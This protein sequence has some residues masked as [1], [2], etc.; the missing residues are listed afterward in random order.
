[1]FEG[2]VRAHCWHCCL[3]PPFVFGAAL[4]RLR[5]LPLEHRPAAPCS[6]AGARRPPPAARRPPPCSHP[7]TRAARSP[8]ARPVPQRWAA[9]GRPGCRGRWRRAW[10]APV[11]A[12]SVQAGLQ[13]EHLT[14][15]SSP[16]SNPTS[17]PPCVFLCVCPREL[18]TPPLPGCR[19]R[20]RRPLDSIQ[21]RA[22][23]L[24]HAL[25][26]RGWVAH[27]V[28]AQSP[29]FPL[30]LPALVSTPSTALRWPRRGRRPVHVTLAGASLAQ[31]RS[32]AA[33]K[34]APHY[35]KGGPCRKAQAAKQIWETWNSIPK[36][37]QEPR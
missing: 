7:G 5:P 21:L 10:E 4:V 20:A 26:R 8:H 25:N 1:M 24:E 32:T 34:G 14:L 17:A 30:H 33:S 37:Q 28:S 19:G 11:P 23:T 9:C 36:A 3:L 15:W 6:G 13:A 27:G 22:S 2:C 35:L 18:Q 29:L 12:R 31:E 16:E